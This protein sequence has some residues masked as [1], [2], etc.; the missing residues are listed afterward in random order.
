MSGTTLQIWT[1][2]PVDI[3][4]ALAANGWR[5]EGGIVARDFGP[6][7]AWV[8][9]PKE[10]VASDIDLG[11]RSLLPSANYL[12]ELSTEG[13]DEQAIP[14]LENIVDVVLPG[15]IVLSDLIWAWTRE[16]ERIERTS[17][18]KVRY[19]D[20]R[21]LQLS[22]WAPG[23]PLLV[24]SGI[25]ELVHLFEERLPEVVPTRWDDS[26]P[27]G[28]YLR[29]EGIDG[30]I[31]FLNETRFPLQPILVVEPPA[32]RLN[33]ANSW[34]GGPFE[35]F[36]AVSVDL[37]LNISLAADM[38]G[39]QRFGAI[40][41]GVSEI[42][43]PFYAE[44]RVAEKDLA[45]PVVLSSRWAGFPLDHNP[46]AIVVGQPYSEWWACDEGVVLWDGSWFWGTS[47][48]DAGGVEPSPVPPL[49]LLA[50][51]NAAGLSGKPEVWPF[52]DKRELR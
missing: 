30:L 13:G 42:V 39:E 3:R 31:G 7:R 20:G 24:E 8:G 48:W 4:S 37:E 15:N 12:I 1:D 14:V 28:H 47:D 21:V 35:S 49:Q 17:D 9:P 52:S 27:A 34:W 16:G 51:R 22:W 2:V 25:S 5:V 32:L 11:I 23:G 50:R 19:S 10:I 6:W 26:E 46:M 33:I 45:A 40:L 18:S 36:C 41:A 44:A 29:D 38:E 43:K